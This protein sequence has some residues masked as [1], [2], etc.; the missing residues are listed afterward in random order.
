MLLQLNLD[1]IKPKLLSSNESDH[2]TSF[3]TN[4]IIEFIKS[5][6][7]C[8]F[9][10]KDD[11]SNSRYTDINSAL[12]SNNT[13]MTQL[14]LIADD[15]KDE[16]LFNFIGATMEYNEEIEPKEVDESGNVIKEAVTETKTTL[17]LKPIPLAVLAL[18]ACKYLINKLE[19]KEII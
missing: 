5:L 7:P 13:E 17:G 4:D 19:E 8:T 6:N 12:D 2:K 16:E 10:Y 11:S 9:V 3:T 18:T 14:G 1:E 15:I